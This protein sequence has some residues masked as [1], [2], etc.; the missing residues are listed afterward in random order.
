MLLHAMFV[1]HTR[2][3]HDISSAAFA[4]ALIGAV[5]AYLFIMG[6]K[7]THG[8]TTIVGGKRVVPTNGFFH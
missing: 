5:A 3:H 7:K 2:R 8:I 6:W 4:Y 1:S